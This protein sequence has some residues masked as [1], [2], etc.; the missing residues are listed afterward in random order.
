V[1]PAG[2][3]RFVFLPGRGGQAA[4]T[5]ATA[6]AH[7]AVR[8]PCTT[9]PRPG[10]RPASTPGR[11]LPA[12]FLIRDVPRART[13]ISA[14]ARQGPPAPGSGERGQKLLIARVPVLRREL[15]GPTGRSPARRTPGTVRRQ[16]GQQPRVRRDRLAH[17]AVHDEATRGPC[18]RCV[19]E[20]GHRAVSPYPA[21]PCPAVERGRNE[22]RAAAAIASCCS[23]PRR[24]QPA[25]RPAAGQRPRRPGR[26][27][28]GADQVPAPD[29]RN[30]PG[31]LRPP[32]HR[33]ARDWV[34]VA[35]VLVPGGAGF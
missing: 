21:W 25:S 19:H 18:T 15:A 2:L 17:A 7:S 13:Y 20:P 28:P 4:S 29:S 22:A 8:S 23:S 10:G 34:A 9:R 33:L 14:T 1:V 24:H 32:G 6:A 5:A 3:V 26:P 30:L 35:A 11:E 12:P 16:L 31:P 27:S